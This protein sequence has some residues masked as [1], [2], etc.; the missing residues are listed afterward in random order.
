MIL[1]RHESI[2]KQTHIQ[3]QATRALNRLV[4]WKKEKNKKKKDVLLLCLVSVLLQNTILINV[5]KSA[6]PY[7]MIFKKKNTAPDKI[8]H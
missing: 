8:F 1:F 3:S 2:T 4:P 7:D 6:S 5:Q